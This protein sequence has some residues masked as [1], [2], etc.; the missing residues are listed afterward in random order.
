M[1]APSISPR[2]GG[3]A[4]VLARHVAGVAAL[5]ALAA[6]QCAHAFTP[7][8]VFE[9]VS[10]SVWRIRTYDRQGVALLTGSAVVVGT[11]RLVTNC[12]VLR[13]ADRFVVARD[14]ISYP[15]TLEHWDT[16][17]DLC[18]V[19]AAI[20]DAPAVNLADT[21]KLVVGEDVF[22]LGS[23]QGLE[24]TLSEGLFA[25]AGP[26]CTDT[27]MGYFFAVS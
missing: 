11:E 19:R 13:R 9:K 5:A 22:A 23:P 1:N 27:T 6:L 4:R 7:A 3:W 2:R 25:D 16:A 14:H 15:G 17:R 20:G 10:P 24:L 18:S 12:H 26:P 21:A 8:E